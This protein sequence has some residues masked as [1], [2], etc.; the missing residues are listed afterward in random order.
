MVLTK[1][2]KMYI[3]GLN[4]KKC[5]TKK[6]EKKM[7]KAH[8]GNGAITTLIHYTKKPSPTLYQK[9]ITTGLFLSSY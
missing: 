8:G 7:P 4:N 6:W 2:A 9:S 3:D 1:G 5:I